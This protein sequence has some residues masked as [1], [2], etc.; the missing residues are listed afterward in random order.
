MSATLVVGIAA[1]VILVGAALWFYLTHKAEFDQLHSRFDALEG[2]FTQGLTMLH[3]AVQAPQTVALVTTKPAP[4]PAPPNPQPTAAATPTD[5]TLNTTGKQ[6]PLGQP[7]GFGPAPGAP[8]AQAPAPPVVEHFPRHAEGTLLTQLRVY[9][10]DV[11]KFPD[12][13]KP[14]GFD[15]TIP[16]SGNYKLG[17]GWGAEV[18]EISWTITQGQRIY[19]SPH[20]LL[21][22]FDQGPIHFTCVPNKDASRVKARSGATTGVFYLRKT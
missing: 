4:A 19:V 7:D 13:L 10:E 8:A 22:A 20:D 11:A 18:G 5:L 3:Q 1:V 17:M 12:D 21:M 15:D 14:M 16:E 6:P 9:F 2:Q